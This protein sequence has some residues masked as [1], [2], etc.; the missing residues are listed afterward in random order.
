MSYPLYQAMIKASWCYSRNLYELTCGSTYI[1]TASDEAN[2]RVVADGW[3]TA[4]TQT[5]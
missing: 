1:G 2:A 4:L 3:I 5:A